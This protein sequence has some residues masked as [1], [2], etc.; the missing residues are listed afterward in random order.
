MGEVVNSEHSQQQGPSA[1]TPKQ[2]VGD[3]DQASSK[4]VLSVSK[5]KLQLDDYDL[6]S[7]EGAASEINEGFILFDMTV[8][9]SL[10][11]LVEKCPAK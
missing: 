6:H 7:E 4:E 3:I 5:K 2:C 10:I 9:F 1:E 11:E 8:L